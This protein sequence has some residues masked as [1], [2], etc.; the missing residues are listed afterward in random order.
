MSTSANDGFDFDVSGWPAPPRRRGLLVIGTDTGVGKTLIAGAIA[1]H[2]SAGGRSVEVF[3]PVASGCRRENGQMI[4]DDAEFLAWCAGSSRH[5]SEIVPLMLAPP[6]APN[7]AAEMEDCP[8]DVAAIL[9]AY[10]RLTER[11][12]FVIVEGI[13]GLLCPI[14]NDLWVIHLAR[15]LELPVVI[16]AR[17]GL[18][19]INHTLL[20]LHAARSADL[21]VAGV[22]INQYRPDGGPAMQSSPAQIAERGGVTVLAVVPE[23]ASSSVESRRLGPAVLSA[24]ARVDWAALCDE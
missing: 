11:A 23:D 4:S 16:V 3:K 6:L 14:S 12:E 24:I 15:L 2:L 7:V 5:R 17:A 10:R 19:T 8:I 22:V 13:G 9:D 18:G 1:R 21:R 20:T